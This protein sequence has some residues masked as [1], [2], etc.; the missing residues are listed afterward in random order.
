ML[1]TYHPK[2]SDRR[3][4]WY[5]VDADGKTLGRLATRVAGTLL[6]KTRTDFTPGV[7]LGDHVIVV[8]AAK[9]AVTG[10]KL[11]QK[12]YSR[13][14]GFPGGLRQVT[15]RRQLDRFPDRVIRGA[16]WGMLPHN[17][18]G[19]SLMRKLR[20]YPGPDHPHTAQRPEPLP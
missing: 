12:V 6:G 2:A 14:S 8:N 19:R 16:V 7:D 17:R 13:H 4:R 18:F 20:V 15:L 5:L 3:P 11:D 1:R 9:V 10:K